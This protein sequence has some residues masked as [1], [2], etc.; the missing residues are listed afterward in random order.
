MKSSRAVSKVVHALRFRPN[1]P[2]EGLRPLDIAGNPVYR[3]DP[4]EDDFYRRLVDLRADVQRQAAKAEVSGDSASAARL[5]GEQDALK[6][7]TNATSYGAFVELN[8]TDRGRPEQTTVY[9]L[10]G[11]AFTARVPRHEKPGRYFHPL[12]A[13]LITSAARLMLTLAE[14]LGKREGIDWAFCDTDSIAFVS[15]DGMARE[16]FRRRVERVRAWFSDLSPYESEGDLLKLE[17][18]NYRL[19]DGTLTEELEPLLCY[20]VSPK[21]YALFNVDEDGRPVIRKASAHGLGHL[22][23]PYSDAEAPPDIPSPAVS[24]EKLELE[25]WHYDLW[26]RMA[27]AALAGRLADLSGLPGLVRPAMTSYSV[28]TPKIAEWFERYNKGRPYHRQVRAFGFF[29]SPIVG[30]DGKPLGKRDEQFNLVAP[31][32]TRQSEWLDGEYVDIYSRESVRLSTSAP[33]RAVA[34]VRTY[35][36]IAGRYLVHPDPRRLGPDGERCN[37]GTTGFLSRRHVRA[38]HVQQIGKEANRLE[39]LEA[40]LLG[41]VDELYTRYGSRR[42]DSCGG[43]SLRC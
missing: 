24:L 30:E 12:L 18:V 5:E 31:Y 41:D 7:T 37:R 26:Y 14:Q 4:Y 29:I 34:R 6:R 17:K 20:A 22:L 11:E 39:E 9:G 10:D 19:V 3:V 27:E 25:R 42:R 38:F 36:E 21:R 13:T 40:G 28:T 1:P 2:Q 32:N 43:S 35:R 15:P 8:T 33:G 23:P 16:D